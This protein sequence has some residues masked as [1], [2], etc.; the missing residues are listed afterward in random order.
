M[1]TITIKRNAVLVNSCKTGLLSVENYEVDPL[2]RGIIIHNF[3]QDA[4]K[5][6]SISARRYHYTPSAE[7]VH[8]H[9]MFH[10]TKAVH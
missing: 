1:K 4:K 7:W 3:L 10:K 2:I 8:V 5:R 6:L 9:S